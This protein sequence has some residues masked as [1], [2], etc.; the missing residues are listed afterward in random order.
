MCLPLSIFWLVI[1]ISEH[2]EN[3]GADIITKGGEQNILCAQGGA[4]FLSSRT[5][6]RKKK[7]T[8]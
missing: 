3:G 2:S 7:N 4:E 5:Q 1:G 8:F 6:K